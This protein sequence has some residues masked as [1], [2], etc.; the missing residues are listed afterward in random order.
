[1]R[2]LEKVQVV[3]KFPQIQLVVILLALFSI[4]TIFADERDRTQWLKDAKY[5]IFIHF[6]PNER[7]F[8]L[9]DEFD[10]ETLAKQLE[11]VG[12]EYLVITM[13]QNSGWFNAPNANYDSITGYKPG[14]RCAKRDLILDLHKALAPKGIRLMV[15]LTGQVP[16]ADPA[17]QNAFGLEQGQKDQKLDIEF[18]KKWGS[19]F[20][21]WSDRY[22]DIVSGWWIDGC[23]EWCDFNEE[24]AQIYRDAL[25]HGNPDAIVAFN[26][27]VLRAEWKTSEYT[28]GEIN[29]PLVE[30]V[31]SRWK[32]GAQVQI[33]T[34]LGTSWGNREIRFTDKQWGDWINSVN[35]GGGTA[36]LDVA[37]T[38]DKSI[39]PVGSIGM[40]QFNQ[41]K[42]IKK[43]VR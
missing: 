31:E 38:W 35:Q 1:M 15:Y 24:I 11:E 22:G 19:V 4:T 3:T 2:F 37:P 7:T 5:G 17:A 29:E 18:A 6:L 34:Y 21:E 36:T 30:K 42:T 28:A 14:E 40:E 12:A 13:Y 23:Y 20:Q 43:L 10:V 16:N 39:A 26:P 9:V 33:L 41:L 25:H 32:D 27:G 8:P